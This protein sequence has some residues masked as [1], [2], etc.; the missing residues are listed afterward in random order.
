MSALKRTILRSDAAAIVVL[1]GAI[2]LYLLTSPMAGD[3]WWSDT[4]SHSMNGALILDFIASGDFG[5]PVK[6]VSQYYFR[7]PALTIAI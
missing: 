4:G 3:F 2:V 1:A 5:S 6:F 7:F